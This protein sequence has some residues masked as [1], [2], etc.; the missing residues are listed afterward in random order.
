MYRSYQEFTLQIARWIMSQPGTAWRCVLLLD[1]QRRLVEGDPHALR[2]AIARGADL[3]IY[4]EFI[5]NEHIDPKSDWTDPIQE[6]MD[7][8]CTYHLDGRWVAG[9]LTLRQ[10][11]ELPVGFG[12]RP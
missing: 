1:Q 8:R 11:V 5:H 2:S 9:I 3:R 4:S 12:P 7:M 10:P 6:S